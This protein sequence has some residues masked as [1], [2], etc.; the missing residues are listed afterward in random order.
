MNF[1]SWSSARSSQWRWEKNL[2]LL[3]A[4]GG[5]KESFLNTP[6]HLFLTRPARKTVLPEP[7]QLGLLEPNPS[8]RREIPNC[9]PLY[10][11]VHLT[12]G[13]SEKHLWRK[14]RREKKK[15]WSMLNIKHKI[16]GRSNIKNTSYQ[17]KC[18]K[19][20]SPYQITLS[21]SVR[22]KCNNMQATI[23]V[24]IEWQIK[25]KIKVCAK[26]NLVN[27]NKESRSSRIQSQK[28]LM[29]QRG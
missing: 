17:N 7:N 15:T 18:E 28:H 9:S 27:V 22:Q 1:T 16:I 5:E 20:A 25:I 2:L 21:H 10:H 14:V 13:K 11:P 12:W 3:P 24:K 4:A 23:T 6:E 29:R 19:C 26:I 8:G